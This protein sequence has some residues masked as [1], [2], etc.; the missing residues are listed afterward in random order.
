MT[1]NILHLPMVSK[2]THSHIRLPP[3]ISVG[4]SNKYFK[5]SW[6]KMGLSC[7][8]HHLPSLHT[9]FL[10]T[11]P[12]LLKLETWQSIT[13]VSPPPAITK[14][15]PLCFQNTSQL[16]LP[17]MPGHHHGPCYIISGLDNSRR[18]VSCL[19]RSVLGSPLP[20]L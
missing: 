16:P 20:S 10:I 5:H 18:T 2:F 7:F 17:H 11:A 1:L 8:P 6:S 12:S 4:M 14:S 19:P 15:H 9:G 3:A 13:L